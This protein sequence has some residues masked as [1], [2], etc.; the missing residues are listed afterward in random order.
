MLARNDLEALH[1]APYHCNQTSN[2]PTYCHQVGKS[3]HQAVHLISVKNRLSRPTL[4]MNIGQVD[5]PV[6]CERAKNRTNT[7]PRP[8]SDMLKPHLLVELADVDNASSCQG[9]DGPTGSWKAT[10]NRD[11]KMNFYKNCLAILL[12]FACLTTASSQTVLLKSASKLPATVVTNKTGYKLRIHVFYG[13]DTVRGIAFHEAD[14]PKDGTINLDK[15]AKATGVKQGGKYYL[16]IWRKGWGAIPL[17]QHWKRDVVV[18]G[19]STLRGSK[20]KVY[21]KN[22]S[23]PGSTIQISNQTKKNVRA[24]I[25]NASDGLKFIPAHNYT[26]KPGK[27]LRKPYFS[28][29][30]YRLNLSIDGKSFYSKVVPA[31]TFVA[32]IPAGNTIKVATYNAKLMA[33]PLS[34]NKSYSFDG[35]TTNYE[36]RLTAISGIGSQLNWQSNKK[37]LKGFDIVGLQEIW[38]HTHVGDSHYVQIHN[39][40]ENLGFTGNNIVRGT[41]K[42]FERGWHHG[43][44]IASKFPVLK[45]D[46]LKFGVAS[47]P[48]TADMLVEKGAIFAQVKM[49]DRLIAVFNTHLQADE[50]TLQSA[51]RAKQLKLLREF[52]RKNSTGADAVIVLGDFNVGRGSN[53]QSQWQTNA[54]LYGDWS[55]FSDHA[56]AKPIKKLDYILTSQNLVSTNSSG[57]IGSQWLFANGYGTP[58]FSIKTPANNN[59][60]RHVSDHPLVYGEFKFQ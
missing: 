8:T 28:K 34:G 20:S 48:F 13:H 45:K 56:P 26:V 27:T 35:L 21:A 46:E 5:P 41:G 19:K 15:I 2:R 12:V 44:V 32:I 40:L 22:G 53:E 59:R 37:N 29:A 57:K 55:S 10:K 51:A 52:I 11:R 17:D 7:F 6:S 24:S 42:G 18:F 25:F 3:C 14:F 54:R 38:R 60:N 1:K 31:R 4:V 30:S 9:R 23:S 43:L 39:R 36:K 50:K 47:N 33:A 58:V 16:N 49:G